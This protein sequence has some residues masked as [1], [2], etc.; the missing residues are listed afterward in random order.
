[1]LDS[2]SKLLNALVCL[3]KMVEFNTM[4]LV[5]I[6]GLETLLQSGNSFVKSV[7]H[8]HR[9]HLVNVTG[10]L[11]KMDLQLVQLM[12]Y[13]PASNLSS[14]LESLNH[15]LETTI[16]IFG[17][18]ISELPSKYGKASSIVQSFGDARVHTSAVNNY[19]VLHQLCK[20][21]VLVNISQVS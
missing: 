17:T 1:M 7:L 8:T 4:Q 18:R 19:C 9:Y 15:Q 11:V 10:S 5:N 20:Q 13:S 14:L 2:Y 21:L 6:L 12:L 3:Y 16:I